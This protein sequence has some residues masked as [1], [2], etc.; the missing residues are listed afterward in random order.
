[1]NGANF[2]VN[3]KLHSKNSESQEK[4]DFVFPWLDPLSAF[5]GKQAV[6]SLSFFSPKKSRRKKI[7]FEGKADE[8]LP[9]LTSEFVSGD[10]TPAGPAH[11]EKFIK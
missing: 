8:S 1:L 2:R 4:D 10:E 5:G 3:N 6:V 9:R 11:G 7:F